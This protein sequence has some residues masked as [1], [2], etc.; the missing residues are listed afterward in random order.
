MSGP[1]LP[2]RAPGP[3]VPR[4]PAPGTW[5]LRPDPQVPE[6]WIPPRE[7]GAG[8]TTGP[9]PLPESKTG[10]TTGPADPHP[11]SGTGRITRPADPHPGAGAGRTTGPGPRPGPEDGRTTGPLASRRLSDDGPVSGAVVPGPGTRVERRAAGP[12]APRPGGEVV[13]SWPEVLGTTL[14]LWLARRPLHHRVLGALVAMLVVFAAG[15]LTVGLIRHSGAGRPAR[16]GSTGGASSTIGLAPVQ[17]AAAA[18]QSAAT[19]IS[20]EVSHSAVVSCDPAMCAALESRGFPAGDLMALGPGSGDPLGSAVVVSTAAVRSLF[21]SR[22]TT[23][24]APTVM[25]SFG[26]GSA[27]I[28]VRAYA[29]GGAVAYLAALRADLLSRQRVGRLLVGNSRVIAPAAA[30]RQLA[31]GQVDSRLLIIIGTLSH[32]GP[33]RIVSFGD[34]GPGASGAVPLRAVQVASPPGAKSGYLPSLIASLR[35]ANPP[36]LAS[37]AT[38]TRLADGQ[39][40]VQ[41][42]FDAPSPLGLL[43]G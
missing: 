1:G 32:Q 13:P 2:R 29:E 24:Y 11:G 3:A 7:A 35:A 22:L 18:R 33:V 28:D 5:T 15:G 8:R 34:S 39:Q 42:V 17:A 6:P 37:S 4:S 23:V 9:E 40:V 30:R 38:V 21:G 19:W 10:P 41:I 26:S 27:Q 31:A 25:A 20:A 43:S 12:V 14:Q 36:Y 16:G